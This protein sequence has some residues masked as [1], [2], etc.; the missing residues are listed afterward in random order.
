MLQ[1]ATGGTVPKIPLPSVNIAHRLIAELDCQGSQTSHWIGRKIGDYGIF[2]DPDVIRHHLGL[3]SPGS[4]DGEANRECAGQGVGVRWVLQGTGGLPSPKS[5]S[6]VLIAPVEVSVKTT[7][8]GTW[9]VRGE[10]VKP[11]TGGGART[12]M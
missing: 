12:V 3:G 10:A 8:N 4:G 1:R 6:Q 7:V 9:P 2:A 5:H 11:A